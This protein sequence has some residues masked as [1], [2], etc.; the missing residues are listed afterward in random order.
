MA[1]IQT[2]TTVKGS[3]PKRKLL[4]TRVDLT[5]MVD[6]GFLLITFFIFTTTLS[7]PSV[8]KLNLPQDGLLSVVSEDKTLTLVLVDRKIEYY[9]GAN[10]EKMQFTDYSPSGIRSKIQMM[11]TTISHRFKDASQLYIIIKPAG[12]ST[13]KNVVT[14]L[15]EML[16][17]NIKRYVLTEADKEENNVIR[18]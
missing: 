6:L 2:K 3:K 9:T 7:Q 14:I 1:E 17:N 13:Y 12:Q 11:Q 8:L 15:D 16:I 18:N 5:P 4:S 10:A